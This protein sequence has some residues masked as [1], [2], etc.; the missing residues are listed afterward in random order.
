MDKIGN[1]LAMDIIIS[2]K[3]KYVRKIVLKE[4]KYEFRKVIFTKQ[5]ARII[6]YSSAPEK[7]IVGHVKYN[8]YLF[9]RPED[10]WSKTHHAAGISFKEFS[11]YFN[12]RSIA[13]AIDLKELE[14]YETPINPYSLDINFRPPQSFMYY[15]AS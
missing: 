13:Y 6:I 7:I 10:V 12:N 2:I 3:P 11:S 14:V 5:P 4:K 15:K 1:F 9:G 8:G